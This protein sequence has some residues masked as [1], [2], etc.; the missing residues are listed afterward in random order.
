MKILVVCDDVKSGGIEKS[1]VNFSNIFGSNYKNLEFDYFL[2][3]KDGSFVQDLPKSVNLIVCKNGKFMK[4]GREKNLKLSFFEKL[5]YFIF[6]AFRKIKLKKFAY[7]FLF[8]KLKTKYDLVISFRAL[9]F[10]MAF[11]KY[12]VDAKKRV[13]LHHG[14][15]Q[16]IF[17]D[18]GNK[19][20]DR[21]LVENCFKYNDEVWAVSK[22]CKNSLE[23]E[24][25]DLGKFDFLYNT[26]NEQDVI[27]KKDEIQVS[28]DETKLNIV[29][30]SRL[31]KEKGLLRALQAF[32]K[33]K[34][35]DFNFCWHICGD[36]PLRNDMEKLIKEN[37][38]EK[39]VI[40]YG[41][42]KNPYPYIKSA[43]L[44]FLPS[45]YEAAPMVYAEAMTLKVPVL[46]TQLISSKELVGD[47][48]FE[49]YNSKEG[50]Y[51]TLKEILENPKQIQAKKALL[52]NY[53]Y[54]NDKI[55]EKLYE[56]VN[57]K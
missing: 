42:Q 38:M 24:F 53:H 5:K 13:V 10:V 16:S 27:A 34:K 20:D 45:F 3:N 37:G 46:T 44:F 50:I 2:F 52:Q 23:Q 15:A 32:V 57:N 51:Q 17:L 47:L 36:G 30:V 1:F 9:E 12:C 21:K 41:N 54:D 31:S 26:F 29:S 28:Y 49:C 55:K 4:S 33:L 7:R 22:S 6:R 35:E 43:D 48:G 8:G 40:L 25:N 11:S 19:E 56:M 14:F 18:T 39:N